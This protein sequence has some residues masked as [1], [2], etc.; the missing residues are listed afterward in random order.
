MNRY[1][2]YLKD[3]EQHKRLIAVLEGREAAMLLCKVLNDK[4][5]AAVGMDFDEILEFAEMNGL[6]TLTK[7]HI[8]EVKVM[9]SH[10]TFE[11]VK[12]KWSIDY[13]IFE[14]D[15]D[16]THYDHCTSD[17]YFFH[18]HDFMEFDEDYYDDLHFDH[19]MGCYYD[20]DLKHI[21]QNKLEKICQW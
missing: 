9:G 16:T 15:W 19:N 7:S 14:A 11:E 20:L 6:L 21:N 5:D 18:N 8:R 10:F 13:S 3:Y 2:V 4:C 17:V 12:Y 1:V